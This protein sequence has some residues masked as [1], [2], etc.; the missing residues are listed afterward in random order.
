MSDFLVK[1]WVGQRVTVTLRAAI[2]TKIKGVVAEADNAF[3]VL[4]QTNQLRLLIPF[5]S[6]LHVEEDAG[7][8]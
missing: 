2:P 6:V 7:T 4:E 8:P 3:L 5:S 1:H